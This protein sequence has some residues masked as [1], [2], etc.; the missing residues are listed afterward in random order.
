[1]CNIPPKE[2]NGG[3]FRIIFISDS[4]GRGDNTYGGWLPS[5]IGYKVVDMINKVM[6]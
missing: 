2:D 1:M 6:L 5:N 3:K 4:V